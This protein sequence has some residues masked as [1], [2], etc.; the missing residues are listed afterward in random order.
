MIDD[1]FRLMNEES[2]RNR[3]CLQNVPEGI[4]VSKLLGYNERR[5]Q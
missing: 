2:M 1:Q 4:E 3:M 5:L